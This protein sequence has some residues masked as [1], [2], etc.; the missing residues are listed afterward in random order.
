MKG[1]ASDDVH[2][3]TSLEVPCQC[4]CFRPGASQRAGYLKLRSDW[5]ASQVEDAWS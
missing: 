2:P 1:A 5:I 3:D 4:P